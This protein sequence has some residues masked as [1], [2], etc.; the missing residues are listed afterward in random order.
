MAN[1]PIPTI[2]PAFIFFGLTISNL[3]KIIPR[4]KVEFLSENAKIE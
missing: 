2:L 4:K 1:T 3:N